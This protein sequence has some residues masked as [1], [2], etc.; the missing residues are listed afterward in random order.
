M[1]KTKLEKA[2]EAIKAEIREEEANA[3]ESD[4]VWGCCDKSLSDG[5]LDGLRSGLSYLEGLN[6]K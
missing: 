4:E 6:K 1:A 2:I 5:V 3:E